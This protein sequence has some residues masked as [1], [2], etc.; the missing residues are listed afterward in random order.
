LK[1]LGGRPQATNGLLRQYMPKGSD[2]G[3]LSQAELDRIAT[4]LNGRPRQ[5]LDWKNPAEKME[6]LL[7]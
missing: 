7:R 5:T 4:E 1:D 2:L 6:E 3:Q